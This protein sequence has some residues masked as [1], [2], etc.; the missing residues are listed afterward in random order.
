MD[1][2]TIPIKALPP[3]IRAKLE[4][5]KNNLEVD[6]L[7]RA[8]FEQTGECVFIIDLDLRYLTANRQA[9]LLLGYDE[10][11]ISGMSV[12]NVISMGELL[13]QQIS[14]GDQ[15]N[16]YERILKKKDGTLIPVEIGTS[17]VS[18]ENGLP[19]YIQSIVR[20][21]SDRKATEK[22]LKRNS[23]I[24]SVISEATA[25]LFRSSN[26]E[27]GISD[28][29][30]S[31][32]NALELFSCVIFEIEDFSG[33]PQIM[34]HYSWTEYNASSFNAKT[35][36]APFI[37]RMVTTPDAVLSEINAGATVDIPQYSFLA[38][39]VQGLLDSRGFLGMFDR[40]NNLSWLLA[41]FDAVQ[42]ATN[43]IGAALQ[44]IQYEETIRL[45]EFRNRMIVESFPDLLIRIDT[46]GFIL[47][48]N[49][50]PNHPLFIHRDMITGRK[51][52]ET[53]PEEIV[54]RIF[55]DENKNSF[56]TDFWL[57]GFQLP[58]S[59]SVYESRLHPINPREALIIIRDITDMVRLNEMKT[60]FINRASHELRTPL[61]AVILMADLIQQG[62]TEDELQEYWRI[63]RNELNRQKNLIDRL[64]MAGRLESGMMKLE[65]VPLDIIPV[66]ADSIQAVKPIANKRNIDLVLNAPQSSVNILGDNSALQQV[67]IN[68]V[69]NATKFSPEDSKVLV[70]ISF[71][72]GFVDVSVTDSGM[73]IAPDAI[74]HLFEK[75]YRAKNVTVAE[76]PG[77]GIGLYIVK[78]IIEELGGT[79]EVKS[80]L[81]KGTAFIVR[82]RPAI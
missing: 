15:A 43:L 65:N 53:W 45:N 37:K 49:S 5:K 66:L 60:D 4:K 29:L 30:A 36:I 40:E 8:L 27:S 24:L 51:L 42:T 75:F 39:P 79:I 3:E 41:D 55:G 14:P 38:I 54:G 74:P 48:Y 80:E 61:T 13:D 81:N 2:K 70:T 23:R 17:I 71:S 31:L 7:G 32:G 6:Q 21:I 52:I 18:D 58:F 63:L 57:Q 47:D 11:E 22:I 68:L 16:I 56:T 73:G 77:S 50:R 46:D 69:T 33:V 34:I 67:F 9:L 82:L 10:R 64:L 44:R 26:I 12:S 20:D 25:R 19:V 28:V 35:A 1:E 76:I 59:S 72:D 62:G 78:S